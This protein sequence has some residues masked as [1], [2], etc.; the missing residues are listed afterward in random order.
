M[1]LLANISIRNI[2]GEDLR[3]SAYERDNGSVYLKEEFWSPGHN[4]TTKLDYPNREAVL[5]AFS[6]RA[7]Q[8]VG[9]HC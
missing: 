3:L 9:A 5:G 2:R 6:L 4:L 1:Q 7:Q 8:L